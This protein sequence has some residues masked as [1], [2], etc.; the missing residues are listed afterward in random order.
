MS[1]ASSTSTAGS[2]APTPPS[3]T[4]NTEATTNTYILNL[5]RPAAS[6]LSDSDPSTP[7]SDISTVAVKDGRT[8]H[9]KHVDLTR[10][11][12]KALGEGVVYGDSEGD[13]PGPGPGPGTGPGTTKDTDEGGGNKEDVE[14]K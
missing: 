6:E 3:T 4:S 12:L 11:R 14:L 8:G 13:G 5:P 7:L 1:P 10:V 2:K 9:H